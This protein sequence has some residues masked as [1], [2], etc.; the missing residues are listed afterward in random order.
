MNS[1]LNNGDGYHD[2]RDG[3]G[4][5][6]GWVRAAARSEDMN[7]NGHGFDGSRDGARGN[8]NEHN[9]VKNSTDDNN[10]EAV[11]TRSPS[12]SVKD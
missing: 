3:S 5:G 7:P 11:G 9:T 8:E 2:S 4:G 1:S 12:S 10:V 6:N